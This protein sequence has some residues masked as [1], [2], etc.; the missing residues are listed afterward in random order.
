M[1]GVGIGGTPYPHSHSKK[2]ILKKIWD[3]EFDYSYL[4]TNQLHYGNNDH[5][6]TSKEL[7]Q[8]VGVSTTVLLPDFSA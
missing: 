6:E 7:H 3:N 4:C 2:K 1:G 8:Q 5:S